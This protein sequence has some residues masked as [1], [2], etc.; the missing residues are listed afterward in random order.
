MI[1]GRFVNGQPL[2]KALV[3]L[4][5]FGIR[6][7]VDFV[8]DTGASNVSLHGAD[9]QALNVPVTKLRGLD[10]DSIGIGGEFPFYQEEATLYFMGTTTMH[11]YG[12]PIKIA[13]KHIKGVPSLLGNQILKYWHV[14]YEPLAMKLWCTP[15]V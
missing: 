5:R 9:I 10:C 2:V 11:K 7:E 8:F 6:H 12:I 4:P 15:R 14:E 3:A 13:Q 1:L